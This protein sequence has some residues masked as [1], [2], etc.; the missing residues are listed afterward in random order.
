MVE[1]NFTPPDVAV[2]I[3]NNSFFNTGC[4]D[5][6]AKAT[7]MCAD[8]KVQVI[9]KINYNFKVSFF[10]FIV[11]VL[12]KFYVEYSKPKWSQSDVYKNFF[13]FKVDWI[14]I[15]LLFTTVALMFV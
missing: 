3:N 8:F 13:A 14:M 4:I 10:L 6:V 1:L 11:V 7:R 2:N 15:L 12:F 9:N 5:E